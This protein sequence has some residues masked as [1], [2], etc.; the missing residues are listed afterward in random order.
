MRLTALQRKVIIQVIA[1][2]LDDTVK[3]TLFGSRVDDKAKGGD[4]DLLVESFKKIDNPAEVKSKI[5]A[6]L[7]IAFQG[8]KI[9]VLLMAP[10]LK[11]YPIHDIAQKTGILL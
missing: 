6:K 7:T 8:L 1:Q 3:I 4:I 2:V 11:H 10:N 5:S 9:D